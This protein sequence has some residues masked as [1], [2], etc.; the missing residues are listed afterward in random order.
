MINLLHF[1]RDVEGWTGDRGGED[2]S[3][4]SGTVSK[5]EEDKDSTFSGTASEG[6]EEDKASSAV[7]H[8]GVIEISNGGVCVQLW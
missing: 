4:F 8:V 3:A 1:L 5:G 7:V 2:K 6:E